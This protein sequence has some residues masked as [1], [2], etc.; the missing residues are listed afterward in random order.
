MARKQRIKNTII[1]LIAFAL[2]AWLLPL[3]IFSKQ[4]AYALATLVLMVYWWITRPVHIAV[5]ALLP[6]VVCSL[7]PVAPIADVLKD[8]FSPIA[9]LLI[10]SNVIIA[11]WVVSGLNKRVALRSLTMIG[12]KLSFQLVIWFILSTVFSMFLPNAVVVVTFCP[13]AAAMIAYTRQTQDDKQDRTI[14]YLIYLSIVW[15]AGIGGFG[16]PLGGAMNLVAIT[17][18][19]NL[20]GEEFMYIT[21]TLKMLPY[22]IALAIGTCVYL[23]TIKTKTSHLWGSKD[24]FKGEYAA[25]GKMKSSEIKALTL[26]VLA[27]ILAFS[28]PLYQAFLPEF[29]PFYAFLLMGGLAFFM[30]G[31]EKQPLITWEVAAKKINW[32]MIILFSGGLAVGKLLISTGA[33]IT[34]ADLVTQT[35]ITSVYVYILLFIALGMFLAN[36]SSNTAATSV[37][38]PIVISIATLLGFQVLPLVYIAVAACNCAFILPTS[39]RAIPVGFGLDVKYMFNKGLLAVLVTFVILTIGAYVSLIG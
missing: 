34:I 17:H 28:R 2:I 36:T 18:I 3:S 39:I 15:G 9:V 26:F 16:T 37:L 8:Y 27:I 11:C 10:G 6:I 32:G 19:E 7:F 1:G 33:A 31:E 12:T 29:K 24:Y 22:L 4:S 35:Q 13:I 30:T 21:W 14:E 25:L 20:T 5:T 38:I 23:L